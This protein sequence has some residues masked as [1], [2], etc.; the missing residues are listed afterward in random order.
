MVQ[1]FIIRS[2]S[3]DTMLIKASLRQFAAVIGNHPQLLYIIIVIIIIV[4]IISGLLFAL[5]AYSFKHFEI[6]KRSKT[7]ANH[8]L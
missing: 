6:H 7:D 8:V 3:N 2:H 5:S 1:N 4:I